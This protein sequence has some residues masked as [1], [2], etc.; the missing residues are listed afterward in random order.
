MEKPHEHS[1]SRLNKGK[2][3]PSIKSKSLLNVADLNT[4]NINNKPL[5]YFTKMTD[6]FNTAT[7][8]DKNMNKFS[9]ELEGFKKEEKSA[10]VIKSFIKNNINRKK[11]LKESKAKIEMTKSLADTFDVSQYKMKIVYKKRKEKVIK[12]D[13][14]KIYLNKQQNQIKI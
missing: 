9:P 3:E 12:T 5:K 2:K 13:Q 7:K 10:N 11:D 1:L 6:I 4:T 8:S 14:Q